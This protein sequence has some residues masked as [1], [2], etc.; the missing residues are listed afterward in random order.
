[1]SN[2]IQCARNLQEL[3]EDLIDVTFKAKTYL[4]NTGKI[5]FWRA[6]LVRFLNPIT[7]LIPSEN[8]KSELFARINC[9]FIFTDALVGTATGA[10]NTYNNTLYFLEKVNNDAVHQLIK[11]EFYNAVVEKWEISRLIQEEQTY[12]ALFKKALYSDDKETIQRAYHMMGRYYLRVGTFLDKEKMYGY[13]QAA[14]LE[15]W[16]RG[17]DESGL[18]YLGGLANILISLNRLNQA[19]Q[20]LKYWA[21]RRQN[22]NLSSLYHDALYASTWDHI[23]YARQ[24]YDLAEKLFSESYQ[25]YQ[26][27]RHNENLGR[28]LLRIGLI[29][30]K[31]KNYEEAL[32]I[33][34]TANALYIELKNSQYA[35]FSQHGIGWT[36]LNM[37]KFKQAKQILTK[38]LKYAIKNPHILEST[39]TSIREDLAKAESGLSSV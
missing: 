34:E 5:D 8:R 26:M 37:G 6:Q 30:N 21:V 18:G 31:L 38:T 20:L 25:L 35:V 11:I 2:T 17:Q 14:F 28:I 12:T 24:K 16:A 4:V 19:E 29:H 10:K 22:S 39:I 33:Y 9:Q 36:Y 15:I 23:H 13:A 32:T 1:M 3:L 7:D 27:V